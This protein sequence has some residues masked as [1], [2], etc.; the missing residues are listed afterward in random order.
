M[1]KLRVL[2]TWA[3]LSGRFAFADSPAEPYAWMLVAQS[4]EYCFRMIP[5]K[6]HFKDEKKIVDRT[7]FGVASELDENGELKEMWRVE[8]WY[9]FSGHLSNDG[10]YFVRMGPWASDQEGHTDLAVAFYDRGNLLKAYRVKDL[11][12]DDSKLEY[13][14]S[15]YRW[16]PEKQSK[17]TGLVDPW[18]DKLFHLVMIDK[19]AYDFDLASG[20]IATTGKD[21]GAL[22]SRDIRLLEDVEA[23]Q[24]GAALLKSNP[25]A[26]ELE[27]SFDMDE[28]SSSKESKISSIYFEGRE[29]H[30][31]LTPKQDLKHPCEIHSVFPVSADGKLLIGIKADE[32]LAALKIIVAHPYIENRF[33][34]HAAEGIRI[35]VAGDRLHWDTDEVKKMLGLLKMK[36]DSPESLG[37]WA[38]VI[39]DEPNHVYHSFY[40]NVLT[41]Q[42]MLNDTSKWPYGAILLEKNAKLK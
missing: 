31:K 35:R 34:A 7:A 42:I 26:V 28:V 9:A 24:F 23:S 12:K 20:E 19:T 3:V 6:H 27:K 2:I 39:V 38:G 18:K 13:S 41:S 11:I 5:E 10:R 33:R 21:E 29:W 37:D 4:R 40:L 1:S 32:L 25:A 22:S 36:N 30:A 15:H 14:V 16:Q 8:G 17:P